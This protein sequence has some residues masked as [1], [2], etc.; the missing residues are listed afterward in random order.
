MPVGEEM[1]MGEEM[2]M[3]KEMTMGVQL[4]AMAGVYVDQLG[5]VTLH[6]SLIRIEIVCLGWA[7]FTG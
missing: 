4:V 2:A 3:G 7:E 1:T 6:N 5:D